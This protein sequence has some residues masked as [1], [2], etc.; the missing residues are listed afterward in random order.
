[1]DIIT[2]KEVDIISKASHDCK[3]PRRFAQEPFCLVHRVA[4]RARAGCSWL[5][6]ALP[7]NH[8]APV[9]SLLRDL[10]P[11]FVCPFQEERDVDFELCS[12]GEDTVWKEKK[13]V[14]TDV[15]EFVC[16]CP[17]P[18]SSCWSD[19]SKPYGV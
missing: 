9:R 11:S 12:Y 13:A 14:I 15:D 7:V 4:Q 1:M 8:L 2:S 5:C 3:L 6:A 10:T 16:R 19:F 18:K 17:K